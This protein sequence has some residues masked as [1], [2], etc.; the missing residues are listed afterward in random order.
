MASV[1]EVEKNK[2][3]IE[4]EISDD[5]MKEATA[6]AYKKN[7]GRFNVPGFRK[8][9][10]PKAVIEQYYGKGIFF[11]DAFESA[12][13][14]AFNAALDETATKA[15]SRPENVD[16]LSMK[17]GEPV[18]V[19]AEVY[20][21][22]EVKVADYKGVEVEYKKKK[23]LE[24]DVK[25][26]IERIREQN[27]R[28]E[29]VVRAAKN[30]DMVVL[31]YSGSVDGVKFDGGTAE[32]QDLELGSG[33]FIP[34]FEEQ[35]VG[36]K[37]GEE[38]DVNVKFPEEYHAKDLAGKDAVFACKIIAVKEKQLPEL[39]DEFAED[40]SEFDTFEEYKADLKKNLKE[41]ADQENKS[42][43]EDAAVAKVVE[44]TEVDM[45]ECMVDNQIDYQ[46][47]DMQY[48]LMYQGL[49]LE[50]YMQHVGMDL[51]EL[52]KNMRPSAEITAKTRLVLEQIKEDKK[53]EATDAEI[54][55]EIAKIAESGKKDVKEYK[56]S[57]K[58]EELEYIK[59]RVEYDKLISGI[60]KDV[61]IVEPKKAA[62]GKDE[63]KAAEKAPAKKEEKAGEGEQKE[64]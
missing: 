36:L 48:S 50:Q 31:D 18:K 49:S 1:K 13:P 2:V 32:A 6:S 58:P 4:F 26:E 57:I 39:D 52:R 35:L 37:A 16:I 19:T 33:R 53:V 20:V 12:F 22:P 54:D 51:N 56:E 14:V 64:D 59:S 5:I 63:D 34:G 24:K 27:A 3:Q 40:V 21:K 8:G 60:I 29:E 11:E 47:Q 30:G 45:P 28:F 7:K 43:M 61:K 23:V 42:G 15:V 41:R 62:A 44:L 46:L 17:E 9:H 25:A 10:A 38:K 55:A